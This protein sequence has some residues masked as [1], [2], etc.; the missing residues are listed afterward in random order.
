LDA[1]PRS[2]VP[3]SALPHIIQGAYKT[4]AGG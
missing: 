4:R 1:P 2:G 3:Q